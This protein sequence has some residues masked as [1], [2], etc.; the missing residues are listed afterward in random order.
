MVSIWATE[1]NFYAFKDF[2]NAVHF[3]AQW[4]PPNTTI[5]W[6]MLQESGV[7]LAIAFLGSFI[8]LW[9]ALPLSFL[10]A[11]KTTPYL[12]VYYLVRLSLN[13]LRS[14][15][16]IIFGLVFLTMLG[17]GPFAA[18]LALILHNIGVLAKI[19]S[20]RIEEAEPGPYEALHA[21]GARGSVASLFGML[22]EIFPTVL[23]QYFYRFEVAIRTSLVLGFVGGGGIGQ[24]LFNHFKTFQYSSVAMD[25]MII[26]VIVIIV[27]I[28]SVKIQKSVS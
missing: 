12:S 23:S 14:I 21:L 26:I 28:L 4:F 1:V 5:L 16:E 17:P 13:F 20:E 9:I 7:T 3:L 18:V 8:G 27:D 24:Y 22:P 6:P 10:A 11:R 25:V 15:P 19:I 2:R